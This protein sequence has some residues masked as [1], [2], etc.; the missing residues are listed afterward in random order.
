MFKKLFLFS[1]FFITQLYFN[2]VFAHVL[3]YQKLNKLEFDLYRNNQLVGQHIYI[4]N[5]NGQSLTVQN[6]INFKIKIFGVTL[7]RYSS[8]GQE[9]YIDGVQIHYIPTPKFLFISPTTILWRKIGYLF[10]IYKV[11]KLIF[12]IEPDIVH[13]HWATSYG[14]L[15]AVSG[16]HPL[17]ISTWGSDIMDSPQKKLDY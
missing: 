2:P 12:S 11:R 10:T 4:F 1:I 3:H 9:K 5:R 8:E 15:A 16:F 17:V 7:Y 13:A 14:L 6:K